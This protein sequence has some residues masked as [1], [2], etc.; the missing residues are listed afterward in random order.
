MEDKKQFL[1]F[2]K[3]DFIIC[4]SPKVEADGKWGGDLGVS[5]ETLDDNG[6]DEEDYFHM[7]QLTTMIAA[8]VNLLE[9]SV[10]FRHAV[11]K[12]VEKLEKMY[13]GEDDIEE[14]TSSI[15]STEDNV[16]KVRFH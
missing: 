3:N 2:G 4:L 14:D 15:L 8:T 10:E 11:M 7:M 6:L 9:D 13:E 5:V 1:E 12:E 16:I